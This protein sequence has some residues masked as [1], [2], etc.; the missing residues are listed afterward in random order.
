[1][2]LQPSRSRLAFVDAARGLAMLLMV[3]GHVA[4]GLL[5]A[6]AKASAFFGHYWHLRGLTAPLF[7]FVSGFAFVIASDKHWL[8]LRRPGPRLWARAKRVGLLLA[9]GTLIQMPRW[10]GALFIDFTLEEWKYVLRSGVLH[11]AALSL[12]TAH[13]LLS[14][15][16]TKR[17]FALFALG[18]GL[19]IFGLAR[20]MTSAPWMD[21][22]PLPLAMLLRTNEG[23]PF[24][25]F[26]WLGHF[27]CGAALA[28]LSLDVPALQ[29]PKRIAVLV[30]GLGVG[31]LLVGLA[32]RELDPGRTALPDY[33]VADPSLTLTR[34]GGAWCLFAG[35]VVLFSRAAGSPAW[36]MAVGA[37][38]LSV[39]VLHL[40][41]LYGVPRFPGL[42]ERLG[43]T[44]ALHEG[45]LLGPLLLALS[46]LAMMGL[47]KL[48]A[49]LKE[50]LLQP[51]GAAEVTPSA[52]S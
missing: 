4:D 48:A 49:A 39:Y 1:M 52:E 32:V 2:S 10:K 27:L 3:Q 37:R 12:L 42:V 33:W 11:I 21:A 13:L 41:A 29:R 45:F 5:S 46:V 40:V 36:L 51:V 15:A 31:M 6:E 50:R 43:G 47:E 38:A 25:V 22:L 20:V 44:L 18:L 26:P 17:Q 23:S 9:L 35:C 34:A 30:G 7:L 16:R 28:R 19:G 14:L 8:E 24:P